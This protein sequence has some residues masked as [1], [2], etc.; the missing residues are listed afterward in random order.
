MPLGDRF[1][2]FRHLGWI[3]QRNKLEKIIVKI[4][5][6]HTV[7]TTVGLYAIQ[8]W[9]EWFG[10]FQNILVNLETM[11]YKVGCNGVQV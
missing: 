11:I 3:E 8:I 1:H 5:N 4:N 10:I 2:W 7:N 9:T 6:K